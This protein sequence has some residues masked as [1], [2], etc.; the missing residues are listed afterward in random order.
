MF[1]RAKVAA[2]TVGSAAAGVVGAPAAAA[3]AE[4]VAVAGG[5]DEESCWGGERECM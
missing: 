5:V 4:G 3:A 2:S 1:S